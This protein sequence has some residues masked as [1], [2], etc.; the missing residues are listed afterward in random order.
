MEFSSRMK[1]YYD[2]SYRADRFDFDGKILTEALSK[3]LKLA[4][5]ISTATDLKR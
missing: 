1:D 2:I 4:D 5:T 3:T